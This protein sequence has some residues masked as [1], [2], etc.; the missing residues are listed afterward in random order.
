MP[1][2]LL[3][4]PIEILDMIIS[5]V[6]PRVPL[7]RCCRLLKDLVEPK[8]YRHVQLTES[9]MRYGYLLD[10]AVLFS[11]DNN[12]PSSYVRC[13]DLGDDWRPVKSS[14]MTRQVIDEKFVP[15]VHT[16]RGN[17]SIANKWVNELQ[18]EK[19]S[20]RVRNSTAYLPLLL[21][22]LPR[23]QRLS[24]TL[25]TRKE[26]RHH[27]EKTLKMIA[28]K[29]RPFD[30]MDALSKLGIVKIRGVLGGRGSDFEHILPYFKLPSMKQLQAFFLGVGTAANN[31]QVSRLA[32]AMVDSDWERQDERPMDI[33]PIASLV[34]FQKLK[35]LKG[36]LWIFFAADPD[37]TEHFV[38]NKL[39]V[40]I[41]TIYFTSYG[42]DIQGF[43][44]SITDLP[45]RV[46]ELLSKKT[47]KFPASENIT[48]NAHSSRWDLDNGNDILALYDLAGE[49]GVTICQHRQW[50]EQAL[51]EPPDWG[52]ESWE[53]YLLCERTEEG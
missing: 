53:R 43:D 15:L 1:S 48:F 21:L 46:E 27:L 24:L 22:S 10:V 38:V 5:Q 41:E 2:L 9:D 11:G 13:L 7:L 16:M 25:P 8:F 44:Y 34:N 40:S 37:E 51:S 49:V 45:V 47:S 19:T 6:R 52:T 39:P 35:N 12:P 50:N 17:I 32:H 31:E 29:K 14:R 26:D 3:S 18:K 42:D 20:A 28:E 23:L 36:A 4:L 33:S 30:A